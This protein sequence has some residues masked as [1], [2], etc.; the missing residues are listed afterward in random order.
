MR[1]AII[2][3]ALLGVLATPRPAAA[4]TGNELLVLCKTETEVTCGLYV[5]GWRDAF[6]AVWAGGILF[7]A[8][9]SYTLI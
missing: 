8:T 6:A 2:V 3:L 4:L 5:L 9:G 7:D 1:Y